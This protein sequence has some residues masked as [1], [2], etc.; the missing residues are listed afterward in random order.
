MEEE[1]RDLGRERAHPALE[2]SHSRQFLSKR[3]G[4][5]EGAWSSFEPQTQARSPSAH[6][7]T[8]PW[9]QAILSSVASGRASVGSGLCWLSSHPLWCPHPTTFG[10]PQQFSGSTPWERPGMCKTLPETRDHSSSQRQGSAAE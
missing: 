5:G 8:P 7:P 1:D 2:V 4:P 6:C 10:S 9:P 3:Q